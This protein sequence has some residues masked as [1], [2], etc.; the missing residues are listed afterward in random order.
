VPQR[1]EEL[2]IEQLGEQTP[3]IEEAAA[4]AFGFAASARA[5]S[6]GL[7]VLPVLF[8]ILA[9][10]P[11]PRSPLVGADEWYHRRL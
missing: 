4:A 6:G 7:V 9:S 3:R 5:G 1:E 10:S 8:D 2:A 11:A